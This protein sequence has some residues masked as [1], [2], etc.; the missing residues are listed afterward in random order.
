MNFANAAFAAAFE[1]MGL[2]A[3]DHSFTGTARTEDGF[4]TPPFS[5]WWLEGKLELQFAALAG[6]IRDI[7]A[8][9]GDWQVAGKDGVVRPLE[10][11]D[12][13]I[14]CRTKSDIAGIALALSKL[15]IKVA[16]ERGGLMMTPHVELVISAFRW[17]ADPTDR[18]AL[19]E[20]ARFFDDDPASARWLEASS[21]E[22][23]DAELQLLVPIAP[24]LET[25]RA[26]QLSLTPAE[27]LD[28]ILLLPQISRLLER[29][30]DLTICLDDLE[31]LRGFARSYEGNCASSGA[32]ATLSGLILSLQQAE[33]A[34][35]KSLQADAVNVITYHGAK[36]LE[37]PL[38]VLASLAWESKARL[39][40]PVAEADGALDWNEPLAMR[41]V[42][43]WPWPYGSQEKD[44]H[45]DTTAPSAAIG[46]AAA[47]SARDEDTRLLYV[48]ATRARDYLI[49]APSAKSGAKWLALLDAAV[50][51]RVTLPTADGNDLNASGTAFACRT[52]TLAVDDTPVA[53]VVAPSHVG[54]ERATVARAPLFRQPSHEA[55][56][57]AYRVVEK[58]ELGP[59]LPLVGAPDM[60]RL[61]EAVH[62]IFAADDRKA[63]QSDRLERALSILQ[64]WNVHEVQAD[65]VLSACT[66]LYDHFKGRWPDA[67]MR[68]EIPISARLGDQLIS[69]RIDL[70]VEHAA[71]LAIIDHKSF[72]GS[73]DNW[74]AKA[75]GYGPQLGLYAKAAKLAVGHN[76]CDDLF[77]HMPIVGALLRLEPESKFCMTRIR[78]ID[79]ETTGLAPP[80][81]I[82][83]IGRSDLIWGEGAP[84]IH[85]PLAW[86]YRPLNGI[87]PDNMA[88]H[89]ITEEDIGPN[90]PVC[91]R[92]S[93][94]GR[95]IPPE[96]ARNPCGA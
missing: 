48:G 14:L 42:R 29:W 36:G 90:A 58:V 11:G 83:E 81:E 17:V 59:R 21:A 74:D 63:D 89:H 39:Y 46:Q 38:V 44:V 82:I 50:S 12:V 9:N 67:R 33:P 53:P 69:G 86:L 87:P 55:N 40:E 93:F 91:T 22:D 65:D 88:V 61:G 34:R 2:P 47:K 79:L 24:A 5:T 41:W 51:G 54:P 26:D 52:L 49:F 28:A 62:A 72:P 80:A 30:G 37:W 8:N 27:M 16:V 3:D 76:A 4:T 18:L 20:L 31:A 35:P 10:P 43:F 95:D 66:R 60:A 68:R 7:L 75:V 23:P 64:R 57:I 85:D 1:D 96:R 70:L 56:D 13:A 19:A 73:R 92:E 6:Q 45:L 32:P 25:L 71:G 84:V 94:K 15:G 78:V 77:V